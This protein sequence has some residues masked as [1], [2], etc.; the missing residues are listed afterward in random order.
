MQE[1]SIL[2]IIYFLSFAEIQSISEGKEKK[3]FK[4]RGRIKRASA[5]VISFS[6]SP[7]TY[8]QIYY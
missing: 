1:R 4:T 8:I 6:L 7:Y 2:Y 3:C 5:M